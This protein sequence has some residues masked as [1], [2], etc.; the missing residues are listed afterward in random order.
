MTRRPHL[1]AIAGGSCSGKTT[2]A[3]ALAERL[4]PASVTVI[5]LDS[6]YRNLSPVAIEDVASYNFD[7]PA[8]LDDGLLTDQIGR[9]AEGEAIAKPIYDHKT[10]T[11]ARGTETVSPGDYVIIEGLFALYWE[12][13]AA[14]APTKVFVDA[15]HA[16]C[17]ERRQRRDITERGRTPEEV[18]RRYETM[19]RPM[20]DRYV[21][22]TR[23]WADIVADGTDPVERT[24]SAILQ[25]ITP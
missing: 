11:R 16:V 1:I 8:A 7:H 5:A 6:Y 25:R 19:V 4:A 17:L 18:A 23:R 14:L 22:P 21:A 24:V 15:P 13:V 20:F 12:R 2:I 9:L 3:L 10:H